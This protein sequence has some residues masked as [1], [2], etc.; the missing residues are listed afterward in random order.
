MLNN[1][2]IY[3]NYGDAS[4]MKTNLQKNVCVDVT[5]EFVRDE[6]ESIIVFVNHVVMWMFSL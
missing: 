5:Y 2:T 4:M 1:I 6:H 3:Y